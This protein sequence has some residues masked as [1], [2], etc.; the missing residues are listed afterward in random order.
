MPQNVITLPPTIVTPDQPLPRPLGPLPG[1]GV[2]AR[3]LRWDGTIPA[4]HEIDAFFSKRG[5]RNEQYR[6]S[7]IMTAFSTQRSIDQSYI[8]FLPFLPADVDSEISAT[9]GHYNS[10]ELETAKFEKNVVDSLISQSTA[11]LAKSNEGAHAFFGRHVLAVEIK[12]VL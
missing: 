6:M 3:P 8:D 4:N 10:P 11:E 7:V 12:K 1:A 9:V 2:V 5:I